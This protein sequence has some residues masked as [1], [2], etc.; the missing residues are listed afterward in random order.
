[1]ERKPAS[2]ISEEPSEGSSSHDESEHS[3]EIRT[4]DNP[5]SQTSFDP[6]TETSESS[7]I[8]SQSEDEEHES[9]NEIRLVSLADNVL[10]Y[11]C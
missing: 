8:L 3:S 9:R 6:K 2:V 1:M 10:W 7:E 11:N 5:S 4:D